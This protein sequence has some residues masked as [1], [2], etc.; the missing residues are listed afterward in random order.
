MVTGGSFPIKA[1]DNTATG[2]LEIRS[3]DSVH[4]DNPTAFELI[5]LG[6]G[7][8][9]PNR[10][11]HPLSIISEL[12]AEGA[13]RGAVSTQLWS[14]RLA[15]DT[16]GQRVYIF[17]AEMKLQSENPID[18]E[19]AGKTMASQSSALLSMPSAV[20]RSAKNA[21]RVISLSNRADGVL[22]FWAF[23]R[24]P[25]RVHFTHVGHRIPELG[26]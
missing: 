6:W 25:V 12:A 10:A 4:L 13:K 20:P 24:R 1:S 2:S 7:F 5:G 9:I 14:E 21:S 17:C 22:R 8:I 23:R 19:S 26:E 3:T 18:S 11:N 16:S 15:L